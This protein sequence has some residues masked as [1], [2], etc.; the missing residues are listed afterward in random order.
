MKKDKISKIFLIIQ[1]C[2]ESGFWFERKHTSQFPVNFRNWCSFQQIATCT[3]NDPTRTRTWNVL[4]QSETPY[5]L[6]HEANC[7]LPKSFPQGIF[8]KARWSFKGKNSD[9]TRTP[10]WNLLIRSQKLH[11]NQLQLVL[12]KCLWNEKFANV[13]MDSSE[14]TFKMTV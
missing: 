8:L 7:Y 6:G 13:I 3:F 2:I 10:T 12:L 5:P 4:I 11:F 14:R 9:P 1:I